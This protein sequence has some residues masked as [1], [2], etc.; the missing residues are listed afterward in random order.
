MTTEAS[1]QQFTGQ[2]Q[3]TGEVFTARADQSLFASM[4]QA[5]I[6]WPV[7]CRNGTCRTCIGRLAKGQVAYD[8]P[9]PGLSAEPRHEVLV[10]A[11]Y[12]GSLTCDLVSF[13]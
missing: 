5:G 10:A 1:T 2:V 4:T 8:V 7:S 3:E 12:V 6:A 11:V 13:C 9:R